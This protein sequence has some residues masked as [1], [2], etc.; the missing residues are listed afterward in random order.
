MGLWVGLFLILIAVFD[1]SRYIALCT[2][3]LHDI[4]AV[5]VCTIY[6][7]DGIVGARERFDKVRNTKLFLSIFKTIT[8]LLTLFADSLLLRSNGRRH[9]L[10]DIWRCSVLYSLWD[11]T[12][13]IDLQSLIVEEGR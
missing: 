10:L 8:Y 2:R 11:S 6:I 5:F 1:L 9:S 4:Y 13:L 3:F 7:T 12:M